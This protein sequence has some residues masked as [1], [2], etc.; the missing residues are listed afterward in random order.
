MVNL[1]SIK[2]IL[3]EEYG[4]IFE[5]KN[6]A[7]ATRSYKQLVEKNKLNT[8]EFVLYYV[9]KFENDGDGVIHNDLIYPMLVALDI[10]EDEE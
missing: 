10:K 6:D 1:Y 9:G 3:A 5:A 4:P 7:V 8:S 2:D